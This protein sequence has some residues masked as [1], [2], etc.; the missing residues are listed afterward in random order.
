MKK[1]R[2]PKGAPVC[3]GGRYCRFGVEHLRPGR[4]V[5]TIL[6]D[7]DFDNKPCPFKKERTDDKE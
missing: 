6:T 1:E 2:L 7:C 5:C 3:G 4:Y